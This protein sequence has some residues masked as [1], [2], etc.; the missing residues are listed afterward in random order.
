MGRGG[1]EP[2]SLSAHAPQTCAYTSSATCPDAL[3]SSKFGDPLQLHPARALEEN[4]R[5]SVAIAK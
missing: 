5:G 3:D 2:P 4:D 1:F